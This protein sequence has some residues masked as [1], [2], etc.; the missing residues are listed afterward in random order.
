MAANNITY[1]RNHAIDL[2]KLIAAFFVI[3]IHT[4]TTSAIDHFEQHSFS[5]IVDNVARFAVPFFFAASGFLID[6]SNARKLAVRL[7]TIAVLCAIWSWIFIFI[8]SHNGLEYPAFTF[9]GNLV[10]NERWNTIYKILFYG[11]ERHLWFFPAYIIAAL[12]IAATRKYIWLLALLAT[13][14]YILGLTGQQF[15]FIYPPQVSFLQEPTYDWLQRTYF[16]R[17]GLFFA[18][19]CMTVGYLISQYRQHVQHVRLPILAITTTAL[20]ALQYFEC[21]TMMNRHN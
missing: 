1:K 2:V 4:K 11:Y 15:K 9:T 12:L 16:T 7:L 5:F 20:F 17:S 18:F 10:W 21:I 8:R 3:C 14:C 13:T 19:P 6:F